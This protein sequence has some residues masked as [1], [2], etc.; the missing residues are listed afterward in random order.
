MYVLWSIG[1]MHNNAC[2]HI[3]IYYDNMARW[4]LNEKYSEPLIIGNF[5]FFLESDNKKNN[6]VN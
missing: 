1:D 2:V 6:G 4:K 3:W 5:F